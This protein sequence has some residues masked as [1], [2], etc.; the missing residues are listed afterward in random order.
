MFSVLLP[1]PDRFDRVQ[2]NVRSEDY[3]SLAGS[4]NS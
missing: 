1:L 4:P 2:R 3:L